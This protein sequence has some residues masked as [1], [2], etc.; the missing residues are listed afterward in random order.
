MTPKLKFLMGGAMV[1]GSAGWLMASSLKTTA[2]Y[3]LTPGEL[4][5][6]VTAD[7]SFHETGVKVGAH[8]VPGTILRAESGREVDFRVTDGTT[9]MRVIYRG[10]IPD[11]FSDSAE[12]V[13]EGRLN[14]EGVFEA[15]TLLAKCGSRFEAAPPGAQHPA[16]IPKEYP[17]G[18]PQQPPTSTPTT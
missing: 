13:V 16:S 8:V 4:H 17:Q 18:Y 7:D 10:I 14:R 5:A 1:L 6:K 11:T 3:Y 2:T 9:E 12:V 15:T